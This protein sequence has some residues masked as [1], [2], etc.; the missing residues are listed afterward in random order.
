MA[1]EVA[2]SCGVPAGFHPLALDPAQLPEAVAELLA[3]LPPAPEGRATEVLADYRQALGLLR[4]QDVLFCALGL[5]QGRDADVHS[6]VLAL[7]AEPLSGA[8]PGLVLADLLARA[9]ADASTAGVQ[10]LELPSGPG[11]LVE[12]L[13][14]RTAPRFDGAGPQ[15]WPVVPVWTGT[16]ALA[17]AAQDRLA[18][19]QLSS[20]ATALAAEY[21]EVLLGTAHTLAF[22][23]PAEPAAVPRPPRSRIADALS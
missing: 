9:T 5:H 6:S 11:L 15:D 20:A 1:V 4:E 2:I 17:S 21:R 16:V 14:E 8:V 3:G 18:L 7:T 13:C 23:A 10:P 22:P 19:L 12:Q